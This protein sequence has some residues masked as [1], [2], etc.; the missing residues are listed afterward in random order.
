VVIENVLS[1]EEVAAARDAFHEDLKTVGID[2]ADTLSGAAAAPAECA[3]KSS[4]SDLCYYGRWK[5]RGRT[6]IRQLLRQCADFKRLR[7]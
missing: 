3:I 6:C 5:L 7:F 2:H 1:E 4:I